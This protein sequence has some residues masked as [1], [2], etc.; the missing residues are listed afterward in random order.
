MSKRPLAQRK[1]WEQQLKSL[2][3]TTPC[4]CPL[5]TYIRIHLDPIA[6]IDQIC[7]Y[8]TDLAPAPKVVRDSEV[9]KDEGCE[10]ASMPVAPGYG[11]GVGDGE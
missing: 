5:S 10:D 9:C 4:P 1:T 11:V 8:T 6:P 7:G 3:C 2:N